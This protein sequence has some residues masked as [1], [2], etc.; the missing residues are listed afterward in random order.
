M[1]NPKTKFL[2]IFLIVLIVILLLIQ[3]FNKPTAQKE[4]VQPI[5]Q[6]DQ[7]ENKEKLIIT[8]S[9]QELLG[10]TEPLKLSFNVPES[11][12]SINYKLTPDTKVDLSFDSSNKELTIT[13]TA[14]WI[15]NTKY[16]LIINGQTINFT[17]V[18][19]TGI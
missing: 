6:F 5:L 12:S 4:E 16:E 18:E 17:T 2:I 13:P 19:R 3:F 14:A 1:I 7:S 10:V 9:N 11:L 8:S 15:F